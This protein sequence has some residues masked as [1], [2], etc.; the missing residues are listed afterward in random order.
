MKYNL[1]KVMQE[2][3]T[4]EAKRLADVLYDESCLFLCNIGDKY[5]ENINK[6]YWEFK[7]DIQLKMI[8]IC[9]L[10]FKS[11]DY[12]NFSFELDGCIEHHKKYIDFKKKLE[13]I[14]LTK[15]TKMI[16]NEIFE[17]KHK[18]N[19]KS[20]FKVI[21]E[22]CKKFIKGHY[23]SVDY[24]AIIMLLESELINYN[25]HMCDTTFNFS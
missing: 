21:P 10:K 7:T 4:E 23:D 13:K 16:A 22:L 3:I 14:D 17:N 12:K 2:E 5:D 9:D 11:Q 24:T 8:Y 15:V 20:V 18:Y 25:I 19:N 1:L 6:L